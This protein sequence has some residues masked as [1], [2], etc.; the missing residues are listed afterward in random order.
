M[1]RK[2][3]L[4]A[5]VLFLFALFAYYCVVVRPALDGAGN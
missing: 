5:L 1:K 3:L 4:T 2:M